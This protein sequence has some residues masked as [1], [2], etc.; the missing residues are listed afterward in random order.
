M[1]AHMPRISSFINGYVVMLSY[2]LLTRQHNWFSPSVCVSVCACVCV[3]V[4][5]PLASVTTGRVYIICIFTN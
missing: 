1:A 4:R 3:R 5:A 2:I